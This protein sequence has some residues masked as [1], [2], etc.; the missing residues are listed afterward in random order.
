MT[1]DLVMSSRRKMP[2]WE[3]MLPILTGMLI[4][5]L[6][7]QVNLRCSCR[8]GVVPRQIAGLVEFLC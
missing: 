7:V 3:Y 5:L 2:N 1:L 4:T 6:S 8:L